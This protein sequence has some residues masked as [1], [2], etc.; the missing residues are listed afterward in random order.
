ML[1][2]FALCAVLLLPTAALAEDNSEQTEP[3]ISQAADAAHVFRIATGVEKVSGA[4]TAHADVT[5]NLSVTRA[6]VRAMLLKACGRLNNYLDLSGAVEDALL[7]E[8]YIEQFSYTGSIKTDEAFRSNK[9]AVELSVETYQNSVC[10][11]ADV[12]VRDITSIRTAF[13]S[14]TYDG[15]RQTALRMCAD[16][17]GILGITGDMYTLNAGGAIVRNGEWYDDSSLTKKK[18]ICVLYRDGTMEVYLKNSITLEE[19]KQ[20]GDIWQMWVFGPALLDENGESKFEFNCNSNILGENPRTA[21]GYYSPGHYCFV[22]VDGRQA[23]YSEG[24]RM[25]ELSQLMASLGCCV[26]YNLDGGQSASM[27]DGE[28]LINSPS[29]GG[30]ALT[31]IIYLGQP[32]GK[33]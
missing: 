20:T 4:E 31:D 28:K 30:R 6:D 9:V 33:E 18:D 32:L 8:E 14:G 17:N 24:L 16:N 2:L 5:G 13:S 7:G 10:Y 12:Y 1:C 21:I 15:R 3:E 23:P 29:G 25:E 26:A 19:L 11:I 22:V 27:V